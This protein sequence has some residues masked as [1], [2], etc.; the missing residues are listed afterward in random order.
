MQSQFSLRLGMVWLFTN[1][2]DASSNCKFLQALDDDEDMNL[3]HLI[4]I[5][6]RRRKVSL[7]IFKCIE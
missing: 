1:L 7:L 2:P 6:V 3:L 5:K 4:R